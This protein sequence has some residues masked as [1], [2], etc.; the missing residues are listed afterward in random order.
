MHDPRAET[1]EHD[2]RSETK[3]KP[4]QQHPVPPTRPSK[5]TTTIKVE[6]EGEQSGGDAEGVAHD[7][8]DRS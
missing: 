7:P 8:G 1:K 6:E 5:T 2:A 4:K 3:E